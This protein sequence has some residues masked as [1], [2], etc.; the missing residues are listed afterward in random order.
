VHHLSESISFVREY[1]GVSGRRPAANLALL[2][3]YKITHIV[4]ASRISVPNFFENQ[5]RYLSLSIQ[6]RDGRFCMEEMMQ[7]F[8]PVC[9]FIDSA[10]SAGGRVLVHCHQ[11]VSRSSALV[12]AYLLIRDN[13]W[14]LEEAVRQ[15]LRVRP[16]ACPNSSF[17]DALSEVELRIL[18]GRYRA[19]VRD[20]MLVQTNSSYQALWSSRSAPVPTI[21]ADS[22]VASPLATEYSTL[23][24]WNGSG[25]MMT[26]APGRNG[27]QQDT[28]SHVTLSGTRKLQS[29]IPSS[30]PMRC[31]TLFSTSRLSN[32]FSAWTLGTNAERIPEESIQARPL[33]PLLRQDEIDELIKS[34][35]FRVERHRATGNSPSHRGMRYLLLL[36][37]FRSTHNAA[38]DVDTGGKRSFPSM[39][40]P[41]DSTGKGVPD[42]NLEPRTVGPHAF[43]TGQLQRR[44]RVSSDRCYVLHT[45]FSMAFLARLTDSISQR[46]LFQRPAT[47]TSEAVHRVRHRR[48]VSI[49]TQSMQPDL[50]SHPLATTRPEENEWLGDTRLFVW[51]GS[52]APVDLLYASLRLAWNIAITEC[53]YIET[54]EEKLAIRDAL[55]RELDAAL[56]AQQASNHDGMLILHAMPNQPL[57]VVFENHEPEEFTAHL[58][59][60]RSVFSRWFAFGL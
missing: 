10:R 9:D 12:L 14:P 26:G 50:A 51:C 1:M 6:D 18:V 11:G 49:G 47:I 5:F 58:H 34:R 45:P 15:L 25:T 17:L 38:H 42:A 44:A 8:Y 23:G 32:A 43:Y 36:R 46:E 40:G 35:L 59:R 52:R 2:Q 24:S 41:E 4:N 33:A 57:H 16:T 3:Q 60:S 48:S 31:V 55:E 54:F 53:L 19:A 7:L 20:A 13:V 39:M 22:R 30:S 56:K 29:G 21:A 27:T 28:A 37:S